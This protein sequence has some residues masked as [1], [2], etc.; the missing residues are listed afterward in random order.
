[1]NQWNSI[2]NTVIVSGTETGPD[3]KLFFGQDIIECSHANIF[4]VFLPYTVPQLG[5]YIS[6][7]PCGTPCRFPFI[8][9]SCSS[10]MMPVNGWSDNWRISQE[11]NHVFQNKF[12]KEFYYEQCRMLFVIR[13]ISQLHSFASPVY[14]V[15]YLI[16]RSKPR[17]LNICVYLELLICCH[18]WLFS[19]S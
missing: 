15:D 16:R 12:S 17:K 11:Q 9:N 6:F 5:K 13:E 4:N 14:S 8:S 10:Y 19:I 3:F 18:T 2:K 1:M 7:N